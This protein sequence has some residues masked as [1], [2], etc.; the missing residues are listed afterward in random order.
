M[1][2]EA[3]PFWYEKPG[4]LA[5]LI[6]PISWIYGKIASDRMIKAT[7]RKV[8]IPVI[9]IGNF[10]VGGAGKTPT[11]IAIAKAALEMG[12]KPGI[13]TRG[14]GGT[15]SLPTLVD[16]SHHGAKYVGDEPILLAEVAPTMVSQDRHAGAL[17]LIEHGVDIILMDDG[18]QS[19]HLWFDY[20]VLVVDSVRGLGN[21]KVI[22]AGPVRAPLKDQMIYAHA[23]CVIGNGNTADSLVRI[24]ARSAKPVYNAVLKP[25]SVAEFADKKCLA[26]AGIGDPQK[27]FSSLE[28]TGAKLEVTKAFPDHHYYSDD[29]IEELIS[30]AQTSDLELVTTTKDF[31][32]LQSGHGKSKE[33]SEMLTVLDVE[34]VF[35]DPATNSIIID[36][37]MKNFRGK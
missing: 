34:L 15:A 9:C 29:E 11:A 30:L 7:R 20:S 37:A 22:P 23:L 5:A 35:D 21:G 36:R 32:R 13:L 19:A 31:V 28:R 8:G 16:L 4:F 17:A 26:F 1:A 6:T 3:P 27:F 18:F 33:F 14:Y 12:L 10:T 25:K 24:A 2:S